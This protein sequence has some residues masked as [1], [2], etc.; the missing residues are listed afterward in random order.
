MP[1]LATS[2]TILTACSPINVPTRAC[3]RASIRRNTAVRPTDETTTHATSNTGTSH[4]A[5]C[6]KSGSSSPTAWPTLRSL[7]TGPLLL[8]QQ[9]SPISFASSPSRLRSTLPSTLPACS[10]RIRRTCTHTIHSAGTPNT[11]RHSTSSAVSE[12]RCLT[13]TQ[14]MHQRLSTP[15]L[16]LRSAHDILRHLLHHKIHKLTRHTMT[17]TT[18]LPAILACTLSSTSAAA[19]TVAS[20]LSAGTFTTFTSLPL[21]CTGISISCSRASSSFTAGHRVRNTI[22]RHQALPTSPP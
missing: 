9:G 19:F 3:R 11:H 13:T 6:I 17:F 1:K 8:R 10:S 7:L 20:S 18:A 15:N 12:G 21:I 16:A 14:R 4:K 5:T 22:P 2:A